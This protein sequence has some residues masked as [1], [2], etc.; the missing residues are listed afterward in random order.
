MSISPFLAPPILYLVTDPQVDVERLPDLVDAAVAGGVRLVQLR[1]PGLP[2]GELYAIGRRL[3]DALG[4]RAGLIVNDRGDVARAIGAAGVQLGER[5]LPVEA[6]RDI[7][8]AGAL[9]GRSVHSVAA[10]IA[11]ERAGADFLL[12]GTIYATGS[13]P[14]EPGSGPDLVR[15]VAAATSRPLIAIGGITVHNVREVRRAGA[16]GVAVITAISANV[17]PRRAARALRTELERD[18]P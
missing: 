15:E 1:L 5:S 14:G 16:D 10:A 18:D 8:G 6:A 11:A 17:D 9:I 7:L 2:A 13:H 3:L 4:G 12:L